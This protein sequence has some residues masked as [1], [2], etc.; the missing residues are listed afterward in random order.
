M[1]INPYR[2]TLTSDNS[3]RCDETAC[4]NNLISMFQLQK[5]SRKFNYSLKINF[6]QL[7]ILKVFY[8]KNWYPLSVFRSLKKVTGGRLPIKTEIL[9][10]VLNKLLS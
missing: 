7:P 2:Q 5:L 9:L 8:F 4:I 6:I 1:Q 3:N 10:P